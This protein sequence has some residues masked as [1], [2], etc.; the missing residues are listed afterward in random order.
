M[1]LNKAI[2]VLFMLVL[3]SCAT[4]NKVEH[5]WVKSKSEG[6]EKEYIIADS[7]CTAEAYKAIPEL[8][9]SNC[10]DMN[11]SFS[12]G[13]CKGTQSRKTKELEETRAKIYDGCML[14]KGWERQPK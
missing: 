4:Q 13:Y 14:G 1:K 9:A 7:S 2:S 12:R 3:V 5:K 11:S 6:Q 8:S 10:G